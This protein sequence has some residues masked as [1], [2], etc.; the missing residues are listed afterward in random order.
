VPLCRGHHRE[1]HRCG[2]EAAWW[3]KAGMDPAAAA[4]ALWLKT[5]PLPA[6]PSTVSREGVLT[7]TAADPAFSSADAGR[8][9]AARGRR[10]SRGPPLGPNQGTRSRC[11]DLHRIPQR[12]R[13]EFD[14]RSSSL[15]GKTRADRANTV[16]GGGEC[17]HPSLV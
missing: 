3:Q 6:R 16:N 15:P 7:E 12:C 4:R 5:H 9:L 10:W 17:V 8:S 14:Y 13:I 1:V 11:S 2:D